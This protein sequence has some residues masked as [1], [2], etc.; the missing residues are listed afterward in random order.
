MVAGYV[1]QFALPRALGTAAKFGIWILVLSLVSPI[2]NVMTTATVQSVSKFSAESAARAA[3]ATR[4]ALR[5]QGY[6]AGGA[7][8][9]FFLLAPAVAWF[10]HDTELTGALQLAAGVILAY[11]F[12]AVFVGAANGARAFHKQAV[13]DVTF[14]TLR[15][16]LVVGAALLT[17][18]ALA[19]IGGFVAAAGVILVVSILVVGLGPAPSETMPVAPLLR[20]FAGVAIYLLIVNLL[21]FVDGLLLKRLVA[22]AAARAGAADPAQVA[23]TA[24]GYYG[25]VQAI[26]RIPYQLILAVTFVIFPLM[27]RA[28]FERDAGK[29]R[30]YVQAT[31]RYSFV[32]TALFA[33]TLAARPEAIMRLLYKPEYA[34]GAPALLVLIFGYLCFSLFNIA[35][36]IINGAGKTRPTT[37]IGTATLVVAVAANWIAISLALGRSADALVYAAVA[38][39]L[40]MAFGLILSGIYLRR[41]FGAFLPVLTV[42]R[43][44]L[45]AAGALAV[46][47]LWP[48]HGALGGKVGTLGSLTASGLVFLA[49]AVGSGE[50]RVAELLRLRKQG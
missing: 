46:G 31:M 25:A 49:V 27:S 23:N 40:A 10:E 48:A 14:S 22:E 43:V 20:F 12:Y 7:A 13:L 44:A 35:G 2:N 6:I 24:E 38:T 33:A 29:T 3:A 26:A 30:L 42:A 5:M 17:H 37:L 45:A 18:S 4:A 19:A 1:V 47:R 21:M 15:A 32:V 11:G 34:V 50:L 41:E 28:T 16:T 39:S 8:L 9:A 36:T